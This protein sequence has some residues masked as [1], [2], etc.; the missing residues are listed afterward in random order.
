MPND[1][2]SA[3]ATRSL[4]TSAQS[5]AGPIAA[6][7]RI[8]APIGIS[9]TS[10]S[11]VIVIPKARRKP[12]SGE[13]WWKPSTRTGLT[14]RCRSGRRRRRRRSAR[15]APSAQP[16]KSSIE[17]SSSS[18]KRATSAGFGLRRVPGAEEVLERD[19]LALG[20]VEVVEVGLRPPRSAR[21]EVMLPSTSATV[22]SARIE[23]DGRDDVELV[24]AELLER[25]EGLVLPGEQHVADAAL[26]EGGRRAAGAGV[27]HRHVG[28]EL[29]R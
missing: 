17:T 26:G 9:T 20:A 23:S 27:E 18:G 28:E 25:E 12:G 8:S 11:I 5:S 6:P 10:E 7:R 14:S 24:L 19:R 21:G 1:S 2:L 15:A 4:A 13:G 3:A 22:G 29:V 16:P